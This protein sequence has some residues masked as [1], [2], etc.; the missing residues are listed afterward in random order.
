[1]TIILVSHS[2]EE[3]ARYADRIKV[4][5][6]GRLILDDTVSTVFKRRQEIKMAGLSVPGVSEIV[7]EL[8]AA[9]LPIRDDIF[10]V[11]E[12]AEEIL[13]V[14]KEYRVI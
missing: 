1:M 14:L 13:R 2:M 12:A 11:D 4:M 10:T 9:G 8:S 6:E 5:N 3:V 7:A